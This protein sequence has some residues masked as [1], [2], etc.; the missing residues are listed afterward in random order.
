MIIDRSELI[1]EACSWVG[2]PWIHNQALKGVGTDCIQFIV[3]L[4]KMVGSVPESYNSPKYNRDWALH[5]GRSILLEE[6]KKFC[7]KISI[8]KM[9]PGDIIIT[10]QGLCAS[11]AAFYIGD[12]LVIEARIRGGVVRSSLNK[13]SGSI[14]SIW[15]LHV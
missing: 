6:M 11:H 14:N 13:I 10:N 4:G 15:R 1:E 9:L 12:D 7:D 5:N 2:T 8:D 3:V